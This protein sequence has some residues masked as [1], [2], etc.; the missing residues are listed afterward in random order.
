MPGIPQKSIA[1]PAAS[2]GWLGHTWRLV[3]WNVRLARR[4]LM[5]KILLSIL[6]AGFALLI[7]A[8]LL[9][10][11]F[12]SSAVTSSQLSSP[13]PTP[14]STVQ[15]GEG[16]PVPITPPPGA[17][18]PSQAEIQ[19]EKQ[20]FAS[21]LTFP[22]DFVLVGGYTTFLGTILIC[23]LAGALAGNEYSFGTQRLALSYGVSRAQVL[24]GQVGALAVLALSV[25]GGM[26]IL[27]VLVGLTFGPLLGGV[28]PT[29]PPAGLLQLIGFWLVVS[30][31]LFAYALIAL[32][33]ATL[34]R[35]TVAGIAGSLGYLLFE[36]IGLPIIIA[37]AAL[38][39]GFSSTDFT[40][41]QAF[42]LG[43]NLSGLLSGVS[44]SPLDLA[45]GGTSSSGGTIVNP[46]SGLQGLLVLLLYCT[47]FI[48]LSYLVLR[49]RDVTT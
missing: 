26:L 36:S 7:G 10:Y 34:G 31:Y 12:I 38:L 32:L 42:F 22:E 24:A 46:I 11:L 15:Q 18:G 35:S 1:T 20:Q 2:G 29:I 23:I 37:V 25:A 33:L 14:I 16:T 5:S 3:R 39:S 44:Q 45:A 30:L 4:R 47:A 27:G 49:K 48:G 43:P 41:L 19:Q 21:L 13:A 8:L 40:G 6:L 28:I 17:T 9:L